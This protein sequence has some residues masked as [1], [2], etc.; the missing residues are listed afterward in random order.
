[1]FHLCDSSWACGSQAESGKSC[2]YLCMSPRSTIWHPQLENHCK[3]C[4]GITVCHLE[5]EQPR[6]VFRQQSSLSHA[7]V[8]AGVMSVNSVQVLTCHGGRLGAGAHNWQLLGSLLL[9][10][11]RSHIFCSSFLKH[12]CCLLLFCSLQHCSQ[13]GFCS[14]SGSLLSSRNSSH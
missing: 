4:L 7:R 8:L 5:A 10:H 3:A 12:L 9:L 1:M 11:P 13:D 2:L 14:A 6:N